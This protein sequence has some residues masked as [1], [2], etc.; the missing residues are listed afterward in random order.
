MTWELTPSAV[1][2]IVAE[3]FT[4]RQVGTAQLGAALGEVQSEP[5]RVQV[6]A[7][8]TVVELSI[9]PAYPGGDG[10]GVVF[11]LAE[12]NS[13]LADIAPCDDCPEYTFPVLRDDTV[14]FFATAYYDT[15]QWREVTKEV[16]W[17]TSDSAVAPIDT[18]GM[19]TAQTAGRAVIDATFA[20]VTS[21]QV[22]VEVVNEATLESLWILSGGR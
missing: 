1:G 21:N 19:M 8:P 15:G 13:R 17:R 20:A 6:V 16:Q 11:P 2:E 18:Q 12:K 10:T 22:T 7:E 5:M 4:A 14:N 9:Y 3:L